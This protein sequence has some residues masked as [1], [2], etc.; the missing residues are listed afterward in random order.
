MHHIA[1]QLGYTSIS[2]DLVFGLP[3]QTLLDII[4]TV[5]K[6]LE[7]RPER[8]SLYSYA[9]VPWVKGTGQRG[10]SEADLP[11]DE[12]KRE[13]YETAKMML[14]N[15]G[16]VEVG[17]DHFALPTDELAI[18]FNEKTLH[19][20]FMGYTTQKTDLLIGLGMSAISDSW[21]GF[22]QNE[23]NLEDYLAHIKNGQLALTKG[24]VL[25]DTDLIIR[26]HILNLMCHFETVIDSTSHELNEG[27]LERLNPMVNDGLVLIDGNKITVTSEGIPY[28]RNICM[29]FDQYLINHKMEK[30]IFSKTI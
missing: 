15:E 19:R 18:A 9:H 6:T 7:L 23:K 10:Y 13:L 11:K 26:K 28:V 17:M 8:I 20:N 21:F 29:A 4:D 27:I 14:L 16:Y 22:A 1:K 3:K 30:P 5:H 24:H 25:S 2:H 12:D